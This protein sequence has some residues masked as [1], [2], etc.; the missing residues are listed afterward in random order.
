M[1]P[2]AFLAELRVLV[3]TQHPKEALHLTSQ[4]FRSIALS[5]TPEEI[6][7]V[8]DLME[9]AETALDLERT[10]ASA[11]L[12]SDSGVLNPRSA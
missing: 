3:A 12:S 11:D 7:E 8:G 6:V 5:M 10:F 9:W 4:E 2:D 1:T